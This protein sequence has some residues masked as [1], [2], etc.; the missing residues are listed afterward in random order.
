MYYKLGENSDN[1]EL[2]DGV[3]SEEARKILF[4]IRNYVSSKERSLIDIHS[5]IRK[6]ESYSVSSG[7]LRPLIEY[8]IEHEILIRLSSEELTDDKIRK[9]LVQFME[10]NLKG[11]KGTTRSQLVDVGFPGNIEI[12]MITGKDINLFTPIKK[13]KARVK[14]IMKEVEQVVR[15]Y[16]QIEP[17]LPFY[18]CVIE[19]L[20]NYNHWKQHFSL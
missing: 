13:R 5:Y 11:K 2:I 18:E 16:K 4:A 10:T 12:S 14:K 3:N 19:S 15:K 17:I 7:K 6:D 8:L 9:Y 1:D 20:K